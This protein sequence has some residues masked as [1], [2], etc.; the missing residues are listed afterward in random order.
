MRVDVAT[1]LECPAAKAW[2]EVQKSALLLHVAWPLARIVPADS[3]AFPARWQSGLT[4]RC[5]LFVFG[6]IPIGVRTLH[7]EAVDQQA[8]EIRTR[9]QDP[10]VR[11][12][13]HVIAIRPLG[14][15]RS[16]YR[17]TIDIDAGRLTL[18]VWVWTSWFY[19]HRQWRWRALARTL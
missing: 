17:D 10:L 8:C 13:D 9:E 6:I 19:R 4:V 14:P 1:E 18:P 15:G 3:G 11:K 7:F 12:W 16:H 2:E 5:K